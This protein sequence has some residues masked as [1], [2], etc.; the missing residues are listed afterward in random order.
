MNFYLGCAVWSYKEWIGNLYPAKSQPRDFLKLY[1]QRFTTVEGNTTF[2]AIPPEATV[3]KWVEQ[4]SPGFKFCPKLN[5][6]ITHQGLLVPRIR[7]AIAFLERMSG[8]KDRL[9]T[10]FIQLPPSYSPVYFADLAEFLAAAAQTNLPLAVEVRHLD[11]FK[12]EIATRLNNLLAELNI[13]RV[14]LDTRPIYNCPDN[15]QLGSPRKKPKL[16]LQPALIGNTAF[17][18]FISHP[19]LQYSQT[20][21]EQWAIQ[22]QDWLS[23]GKTVY[24]FVHCP[25]EVRSP[26]T[27]KYFFSLLQQQHPDLNS[28]SLPWDNFAPNPTQLSLF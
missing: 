22:L 25:Q 3:N 9:G 26:D 23:Q 19:N 1:S 15:P 10:T 2:Y 28:D 18:R 13:A 5:R 4:T 27:A 24:F 20:Y 7:E 14:L 16:P 12:P 11:W 17:V 21:L 6:Q 8:L